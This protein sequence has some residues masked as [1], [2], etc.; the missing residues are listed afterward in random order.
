[1]NRGKKVTVNYRILRAATNTT[2]Y[3]DALEFVVGE[4]V[5]LDPPTIESVKG[6]VSNREIPSNTSTTETAFTFSGKA[7]AGLSIE[8][9]DDG[10]VLDTLTVKSDGTWEHALDDQP[11]GDRRYTA[12]ACYSAMPESEAWIIKVTEEEILQPP[13]IKEAPNN[14]SLSPF[15]AKDALTALIPGPHTIGTQI[16]VFWKGTDGPGSQ[17]VGPIDVSIQGDQTIPLS[18]A[19]VAFNLDEAVTVTYIVTRNGIPSNPSKPLSLAVL[20]IAD[21][22]PA[23]GMP[24][25]TQ[26]ANNGAGPELNVSALTAAGTMRVNSYPLI[27]LRQYV[28]LRVTG[29]DKNEKNYDKTF[30]QPPT[31]Q[32]NSTWISQGFYTHSIPLL[33]LQDLKDGSELIMEFKVGLGGSQDERQATTFKKRIYT[34]KAVED[35]RPEITSVKGSPSGADIPP[36][37]TTVETAITLSGTATRSLQVE[38]FDGDSPQGIANADADDGEWKLEVRN[39]S[40]A[41]HSFKAKALYGSGKESE[42]RTFT[43]ADELRITHIR[44]PRHMTISPDGKLAYVVCFGDST[45]IGNNSLNIIDLATQTITTSV[46]TS[47]TSSGTVLSPDGRRIYGLFGNYNIIEYDATD[48]TVIRTY[49]RTYY[50]ASL[51]LST[52]NTQFYCVIVNAASMPPGK[53]ELIYAPSGQTVKTIDLGFN[54]RQSLMNPDGSRL[55]VLSHNSIGTA[56]GGVGVIDTSTFRLIASIDTGDNPSTMA[57]RPDW[58][59]IYVARSHYNELIEISTR[60]NSITRRIPTKLKLD[61]LAIT[62]D[63]RYLYGAE[64]SHHYEGTIFDTTTLNARPT[65]TDRSPSA[66]AFSKDGQRVY[67]CNYLDNNLWDASWQ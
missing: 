6:S 45:N 8:L 66:V 41:A 23:M 2:S 35:V 57:V 56:K 22:D 47:G 52:D 39:L 5:K 26:A 12:K 65:L 44:N 29:T 9:R 50:T 34:V 62:P 46:P 21:E 19:V 16:T 54:A 43:V 14:T 17:T 59:F 20:P 53:L 33:D 40:V 7:S 10:E 49:S 3:S 4:A 38:I 37:G 58:E 51:A 61:R 13:S 67:I 31:S 42:V 1:P 63:G 11:M 25:I 30:W 24:L 15:A 55:Y 28:W 48:L 36:G 27:A 32:T 60:T 64:S 18:N